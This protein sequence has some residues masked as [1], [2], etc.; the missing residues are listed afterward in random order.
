MLSKLLCN[1]TTTIFVLCSAVCADQNSIFILKKMIKSCSKL[2][3]N[4]LWQ[5]ECLEKSVLVKSE[6]HDSLKLLHTKI[7]HC[8]YVIRFETH[9]CS[10][11][12]PHHTVHCYAQHCAVLLSVLCAAP[13]RANHQ[14]FP[15]LPMVLASTLLD[16]LSSS[17]DCLLL[18]V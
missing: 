16:N 10:V 15:I 1:K 7:N 14:T 2:V 8:S 9:C 6:V 17:A 13:S 11:S 4:H 5:L 3:K 18:C 12:T